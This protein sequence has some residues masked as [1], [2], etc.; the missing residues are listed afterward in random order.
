MSRGDS[1]AIFA[2]RKA[3]KRIPFDFVFD[4]LA[5]LAVWVRPMFGCHAVY[6]DEKI[7]FVLRERGDP[8]CD[9]GV[10][11][12]TTPAH[13]EELRRGF[14]SM[15]SISVLAA[16]RVTGWQVLPAASDDFEASV[17]RACALV[18]SGDLRIGKAPK[19]R[20]SPVVKRGGA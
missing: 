2:R 6:V 3:A 20:G 11:L 12:A 16:G 4:E 5:D 14:P 8:S 17:L 7:M 19:V 18:R 1:D 10:W 15:R 13:H 9:D